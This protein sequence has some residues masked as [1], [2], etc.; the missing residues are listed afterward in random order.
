LEIS[1]SG[2]IE[3]IIKDPIAWGER[4]VEQFILGNEDKYL[5]AKQLGKDFWDAVED[6]SKG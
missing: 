2:D 6:K 1:L 4:M 3:E 5:E